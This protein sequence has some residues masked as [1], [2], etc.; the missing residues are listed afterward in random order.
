VSVAFN[1]PSEAKIVYTPVNTTLTGSGHI[2]INLNHDGIKDF[3]IQSAVSLI[4]CGG[5]EIHGVVTVKPTTGD[6]VVAS[7]T[8]AAALASGIQVGPTQ[9]FFSNYQSLMTNFLFTR[10]CGHLPYRYGNWFGTHFIAVPAPDTRSKILVN[11]QMHYGALC[12]QREAS[13]GL[14]DFEELCLRNY[15]GR[16]RDWSDVWLVTRRK[17]HSTAPASCRDE[18]PAF[19]IFGHGRSG[20]T[21]EVAR[22]SGE[23][24]WGGRVHLHSAMFSQSAPRKN[25]L[26]TI[27]TSARHLLDKL[28]CRGADSLLDVQCSAAQGA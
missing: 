9:R 4:Y 12:H 14:A 16:Y 10:G 17:A 11:G 15:W 3:D 5:H 23:R 27:S 13:A 8:H 26:F 19:C 25:S 2:K 22:P 1:V 28:P 6:G 24:R 7:G 21:V 18:N 20:F